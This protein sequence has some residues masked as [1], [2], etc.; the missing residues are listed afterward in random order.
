MNY[1]NSSLYKLSEFKSYTRIIMIN[2]RMKYKYNWFSSIS[3]RNLPNFR[4]YLY[5]ICLI[6]LNS[7]S[8][9]FSHKLVLIQVTNTFEVVILTAIYETYHS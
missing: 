9:E 3:L 4:Y 2:K 6:I 1:C 7:L 5:N 8:V